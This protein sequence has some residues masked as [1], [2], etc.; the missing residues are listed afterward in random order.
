M[1]EI[2]IGQAYET[3]VQNCWNWQPLI[4]VFLRQEMQIS[5]K[6]FLINT[7]LRRHQLSYDTHSE[8]VINRAMFD[9]CTLSSFGEVKTDNQIHW[10]YS[11]LYISC[12]Y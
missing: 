2:N 3:T 5:K 9:F 11:T 10:P 6:L 12:T 1:L 7:S 4:N 8:E